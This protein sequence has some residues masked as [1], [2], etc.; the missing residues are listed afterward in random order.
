M[1]IT[2]AVTADDI[3][4]IEAFR[5]L[6]TPIETL[7]AMFFD[8]FKDD[9]PE[10]TQIRAVEGHF[11][12]FFFKR[13]PSSDRLRD[14]IFGLYA[15][16][17]GGKPEGV[18]A[19]YKGAVG[20]GSSGGLSGRIPVTLHVTVNP[21]VVARL[22]RASTGWQIID[23][24]DFAEWKSNLPLT[25]WPSAKPPQNKIVLKENRKKRT[26]TATFF[27]NG[28]SGEPIPTVSVGLFKV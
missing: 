4:K 15:S 6:V 17:W 5:L 10:L 7:A 3:A 11:T 1:E 26:V 21:K 12:L 14:I 22:I 9:E 28:L 23:F 18:E 13:I 16:Q 8:A 19:V 25:Y 27:E 20:Y 24:M 2:P